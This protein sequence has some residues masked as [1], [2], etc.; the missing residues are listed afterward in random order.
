MDAGM[1]TRSVH[2]AFAVFCLGAILFGGCTS[3]PDRETVSPQGFATIRNAAPRSSMEKINVARLRMDKPAVE[4][5][6][7]GDVL[8]IYIANVTGNENSEIP[9]HNIGKDSTEAPASGYPFPVRSDGTISLPLLREPIYVEG[10]SIIE[11][12]NAIR[13]AYT[14]QTQFLSEGANI[15]VTMIRRRTY[16]VT[17]IREDTAINSNASI[18]VNKGS[19]ESYFGGMERGNA[20]TLELPAYRND[21]LEALSKSGGL[22]GLNAKNEVII[23]RKGTEDLFETDGDYLPNDLAAWSRSVADHYNRTGEIA[24]LGRGMGIIR[25]PIRVSPCKIPPR[26]TS[27]DVTL[28]DGDVVLI[29]SRDAEVFYTGGMIKG[30]VHPIPRD[31]DL[32][33]L[34]AIATAGGGLGYGWGGGNGGGSTSGNSLFLLPPSRILVLRQVNG[35]QMAIRIPQKEAIRDPSQRVLIEPNDVILLEYTRLEMLFNLIY[36]SVR[37]NI[38]PK[39]LF[40]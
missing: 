14:V 3:I 29:Q 18:N 23:L 4:R 39:E 40:D 1:T 9:I 30:G 35:Q 11:A 28:H 25:I 6:A 7:P 10:M 13:N 34:G 27:D 31:Y 8:G 26:L 16:H 36:S 21:V 5:L 38:N 2:Y 24:G 12:E 17:V 20:V 22:P 15:S 33:V 37:L 32:D 19:M